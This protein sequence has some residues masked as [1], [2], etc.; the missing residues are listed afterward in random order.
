MDRQKSN[1]GEIIY[2]LM[3]GFM[4]VTHKVFLSDAVHL[5]IEIIYIKEFK[6]KSTLRN[7][8]LHDSSSMQYSDLPVILGN[9]FVHFLLKG[10]KD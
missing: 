9:C 3:L 8:V 4:Y 2:V 6:S 5:K 7:N 1:I 10:Q